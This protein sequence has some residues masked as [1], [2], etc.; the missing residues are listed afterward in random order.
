MIPI[1]PATAYT[2]SVNFVT[3]EW[4]TYFSWN[5]TVSRIGNVVGGWRGILMANYALVNHTAS[6]GFFATGN[7]G[8]RIK[9]TDAEAK[10]AMDSFDARDTTGWDDSWLD[11]GAS[12][13]WYLA[14]AAAFGKV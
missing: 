4:N 13:T 14:Y 7:P 1:S 6:Y 11:G 3:Q 9:R 2:R 12:R 10:T 5:G 8:S